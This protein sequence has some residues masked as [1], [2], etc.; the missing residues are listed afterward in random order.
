MTGDAMSKYSTDLI[1]L[2][3]QLRQQEGDSGS[4]HGM[5]GGH[6]ELLQVLRLQADDRWRGW[7]RPAEVVLGGL[8]QV[9]DEAEHGADLA[10]HHGVEGPQHE[11]E[12][13]EV[14]LLVAQGSAHLG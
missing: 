6:G 14:E 11:G 2:Q 10:G 5:G 9:H 7:T 13:R 4:S 1:P 12:G 3:Y 8:P